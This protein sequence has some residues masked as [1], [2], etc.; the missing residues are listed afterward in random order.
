MDSSG[1]SR[2]SRERLYTRAPSRASSASTANTQ[3]TPKSASSSSSYLRETTTHPAHKYHHS[4]CSNGSVAARPVSR[5]SREG[6][7]DP[8]PTATAV[9]SLL[10]ERLQRERKIESERLAS[11]MVDD[12]S[13]STGDIRDRDVPS[14]PIKRS[15]TVTGQ[16]PKS[17]SGDKLAEDTGMGAKQMEKTMSTLHKQNFDLKVELYH[18]RNRQTDLEERVEKLES[19]RNQL[20]DIQESLLAELERR[21]KA[22]GEA[23]DMI[24]KLEG[25]IKKLEWE[26]DA[27]RQIEAD[28]SYRYSHPDQYQ[29][30][31]S[32]AVPYKTN[33]MSLL[34]LPEHI[35]GLE[36]MPSFLTEHT[37]Q[38]ENLRNVVLGGQ[39]SEM[40]LR[41]V[42]ESSV[43]PSEMNRIASPS[44]SVLSKSS[45]T[46]IYGPKDEQNNMGLPPNMV[47]MDGSQVDRSPTP[48]QHATTGHW[49]NQN[50]VHPNRMSAGVSKEGARP[51]TQIQ[52][53]NNVLGPSSPL[54]KLEKLDK[55][56]SITDDVTRSSTP[57]QGR[58]TASSR[59]AR[60]QQQVKTKHEK[61]EALER[62]L[63]NYQKPKEQANV[64]ALPPTPDTV[65]SSILQKHENLTRSQ[66]SLM[67]QAR[68]ASENP[69]P[70]SDR[71]GRSANITSTTSSNLDSRPMSTTA[72]SNR[73]HIPIPS[74]DTN[75]FS[76]LSQLAYSLPPRPRSAAETTCSRAR[77][78]SFVS[79]SESDGGVNA[80]SEVDSFD[81]WMQE[82]MKPDQRK[83]ALSGRHEIGRSISPDLFSF[84]ADSGS[85]E[86]D[87]IFGALKGNGF[88]G[89]PVSAL[90]RDP[91]DEMTY[92]LQSQ[93]GEI[94]DPSA[95]GTAP[96]TPSRRSS[97]HART[98]S[99]NAVSSLGGKLRRSL[100]RDTSTNRVDGRFRSNSI[101]VAAQGEYRMPRP[102]VPNM[103]T[104]RNHYPPI[105]GQV[106]R[107]R[108]FGLN[109][110]FRRPGSE[111][112]SVPSSATD[113]VFPVP[114]AAQLP[115]PTPL[116]PTKPSGR[117]SVPP[118]ATLPWILRPPGVLEDELNRATPPP[119]MRNRAP[120]PAPLT[121]L[122]GFAMGMGLASPVD[123]QKQEIEMAGPNTPTT[124]FRPSSGSGNTTPGGSQNTGKRKWLGLGRVGSLMNRAG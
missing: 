65:S 123:P 115:P 44:L 82:S 108:G 50:K 12:L 34:H 111:S 104:K 75:F 43:D 98:G 18:R 69:Q 27:A 84:P 105:S 67:K 5:V 121:G 62:V 76:N 2:E 102:E 79:D 114:A 35:R 58:S 23:V 97:L 80:Y 99:S 87:A 96:P 57:S 63:I 95:N 77:T 38:T 100:T 39:S 106:P 116:S 14:S 37:E 17:N 8:R 60:P 118:P 103:A 41:K 56:T 45:F 4:H 6:S 72:I 31:P 40:H 20:I 70:A 85:W 51:S 91:I 94:L 55:Q 26:Q 48:T 110:L 74:L 53:L 86:T 3:M 83:E 19:D 52:S 21:D 64:H 33:D 11:K 89:S 16:R 112:N 107:G 68:G 47:G 49:Q 92:T 119:I 46:S 24:V 30:Q 78:D 10:Q 81:Y 1:G 29:P 54:Q 88:I 113:G 28:G 13:A 25:H 9:S 93:Q 22:I 109:S 101:D 42:S 59:S 36:R 7:E 66:D 71:S 90:K 117:S 122:E 61:R 120:P 124:A 73:K 15:A 32:I